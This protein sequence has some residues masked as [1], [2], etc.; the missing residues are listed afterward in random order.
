[1]A[2]KETPRVNPLQASNSRKARF[3]QSYLLLG[4][5]S[6]AGF[7]VDFDSVFRGSIVEDCES[8]AVECAAGHR[9]GAAEIVVDRSPI[10][11]IQPD[12]L[13]C[14]YLSITV[15]G[16]KLGMVAVL[17]QDIF[18]P[19]RSRDDRTSMG[20]R[21]TLVPCDNS[22]SNQTDHENCYVL[23]SQDFFRL[24][25]PYIYSDSQSA[26]IQSLCSEGAIRNILNIP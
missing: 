5:N 26:R 16:L 17:G 8:A 6:G 24:A 4:A 3:N 2:Q 20:R 19:V 12:Y 9:R 15:G 11:E 10:V 21:K 7:A 25:E 13:F 14:A 23:V 1:M 22:N 18:C